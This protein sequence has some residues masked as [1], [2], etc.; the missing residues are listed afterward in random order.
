MTHSYFLCIHVFMNRNKILLFSSL[1]IL[2]SAVCLYAE[3]NDKEGKKEPS[4]KISAPQAANT[5]YVLPDLPYDYNALEP[6]IDEATMRLH[7]DKHH[8]A[9]V[10]GANQAMAKLKEIAEGKGDASL[11]THWVRQLA[12]HGS[13][14]A[15]HSIF[16]KNMTPSPKAA[17]EGGLATAIDKEFG[18][19]AQFLKLF[20][21]ATLG[22]E[23]SGWGIL[24]YDPLSKKLVVLG[25]E[26]HQNL[27]VMGI[28]PLLVCDVWE[29]AYYLKH[30][31]NRGAY[32][33]NF[34]KVINWND[35]E[36]RYTRA[37][38]E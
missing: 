13:G 4:A 2:A 37:K 7:H 17:P 9:Y 16:W 15:M 31:N 6:H 32:I 12:F 19:Y 8:A 29:H 27:S 36:Q 14:H 24:G 5:P 26:K 38:Q 35:V 30:Q 34:L 28:T 33:D 20:K 11:T 23:G 18:S 25:V 10:A 1:S 3:P 22:V 21:A